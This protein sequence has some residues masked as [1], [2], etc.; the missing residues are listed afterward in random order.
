M[1]V[2]LGSIQP[3]LS[4]T[5]MSW[6]DSQ[7]QLESSPD[8]SPE[9]F[10]STDAAVWSATAPLK[11]VTQVN[12]LRKKGKLPAGSHF[13]PSLQ[14]Y[15]DDSPPIPEEEPVHT[16]SSPGL[17]R[18]VSRLRKP[19][20][21]GSTRRH[22]SVSTPALVRRSTTSFNMWPKKTAHSHASY[23]VRRSAS[24]NGHSAAFFVPRN[25]LNA[26]LSVS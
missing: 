8:L 14:F 6:S 21:K 4:P 7:Y 18:A 24:E 23:E 3:S 16:V 15:N 17:K 26:Y 2:L 25:Q 1:V 11:S 20:P 22:A 13:P 9:L 12:K 19:P 5:I 10:S